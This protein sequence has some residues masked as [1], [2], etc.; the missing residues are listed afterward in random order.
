MELDDS[1]YDLSDPK[2]PTYY[3]RMVDM[4]DFRSPFPSNDPGDETTEESE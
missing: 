3:E 2:H 4:A 1:G